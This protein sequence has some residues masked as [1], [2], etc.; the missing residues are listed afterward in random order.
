[1]SFNE[2][3]KELK[4]LEKEKIIA[5]L[6]DLYKKH[7][8]VREYLDFYVNSD[9]DSLLVKYHDKIYEAFYPSRGTNFKIKDAKQ[10]LADFKKLDCGEDLYAELLLFYVET[11]I[12][13]TN[14]YGDLD[15]GFYKN[16]CKYFAESLTIFQTEGQLDDLQDRAYNV[17]IT[18]SDLSS[19][20]HDYMSDIFNDFFPDY[21]E[22]LDDSDNS[23]SE[24]KE[25]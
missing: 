16:I 1:M 7:K 12:N 15:E 17:M 23:I 20:F 9:E 5:I 25:G 22:S 11:G 14:A 8:S 18:T 3:K 10:A 2:V 4:K 24:S 19:G 6:S 13:F 21:Y